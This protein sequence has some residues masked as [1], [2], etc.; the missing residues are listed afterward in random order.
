MECTTGEADELFLTAA[1]TE[2][3]ALITDVNSD[4][5]M[6]GIELGEYAREKFQSLQI[7]VLSGKPHDD[8]PLD[9]HFF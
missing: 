2:L 9:T 6:T 5:E 4:G 1:G 7:V 8:L 3:V